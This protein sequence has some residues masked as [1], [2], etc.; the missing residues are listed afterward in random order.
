MAE[1]A[2]PSHSAFAQRARQRLWRAK[3]ANVKNDHLKKKGCRKS[4]R[5]SD[6]G[7]PRRRCRNAA[8]R[9]A[10]AMQG[11]GHHR[12][13]VR[14]RRRLD[15][16]LREG[17]LPYEH[18]IENPG[19]LR[20]FRR[21]RLGPKLTA[22]FHTDCVDVRCIAHWTRE[23]LPICG[24]SRTLL[25]ICVRAHY[26][27]TRTSGILL[28][29][30]QAPSDAGDQRVRWGDLKR[31][32]ERCRSLWGKDTGLGLYSATNLPGTGFPREKEQ[33]RIDA[34]LV[35]FKSLYRSKG[36]KDAVAALTEGIA[37]F[38]AYAKLRGH[39]E[40]AARVS[41]GSIGKYHMHMVFSALVAS[42]WRPGSSTRG[43]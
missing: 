3:H 37:D 18:K 31:A 8:E 7:R 10:L 6:A 12:T 36:F 40:A 41:P 5:P 4:P 28:P 42:G 39:L 16:C 27:R 11:S 20:W 30:L 24:A 13:C 2:Y 32:L 25:G 23:A 38:D 9:N 43:P 26:N 35:G 33:S 34:M 14:C 21:Y 15:D 17:C 22:R 29:A 1:H 19:R